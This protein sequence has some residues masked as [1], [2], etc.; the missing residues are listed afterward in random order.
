MRAQGKIIV[1]LITKPV[2]LGGLCRAHC[3][4]ALGTDHEAG[5]TLSP[6]LR[7]SDPA[8]AKEPRSPLRLLRHF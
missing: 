2:A 1:N 4:A 6:E 8:C 3:S 5:P 7:A